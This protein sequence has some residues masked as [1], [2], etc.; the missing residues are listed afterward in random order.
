MVNSI[1]VRFMGLSNEAYEKAEQLLMQR[2]AEL[3]AAYEDAKA[4][5]D[6]L[7]STLPSLEALQVEDAEIALARARIVVYL[8]RVE[9]LLM[10]LSGE[11][12]DA[13]LKLSTLE[14][15]RIIEEPFVGLDPVNIRPMFNTAIALVLGG[16]V[17][18]G[19]VFI[20]EY[21][22]KNPLKS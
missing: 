4:T 6:N 1:V 3:E 17:A 22:E 16:M 19:L 8:P 5:H 7:L 15:V 20:L 14:N 2:I 12:H 11:L 9:S 18:L 13:Q 10:S 21:F